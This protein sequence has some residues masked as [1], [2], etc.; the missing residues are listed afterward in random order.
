MGGRKLLAKNVGTKQEAACNGHHC[1]RPSAHACEGHDHRLRGWQQHLNPP[2]CRGHP[3][4]PPISTQPQPLTLW[5][6]KGQLSDFVVEAQGTVGESNADGA[7]LDVQNNLTRTPRRKGNCSI[8][9]G[10]R[11]WT[12]GLGMGN[13]G[14]ERPVP[15]LAASLSCFSLP[16]SS[17]AISRGSR[18]VI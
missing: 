8:C 14:M 10:V 1:V 6:I 9:L 18:K 7:I 15:R 5:R 12:G 17:S 16:T 2:S 11:R 4:F 3:Y 13:R